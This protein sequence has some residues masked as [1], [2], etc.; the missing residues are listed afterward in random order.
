MSIATVF[1]D[2]V[3]DLLVTELGLVPQGA[4]GPG[5]PANIFKTVPPDGLSPEAVVWLNLGDTDL[6]VA[7]LRGPA[8]SGY[9]ETV[10]LEVV[11][12]VESHTANAADAQQT[13]D[14][15]AAQVT[16]AIRQAVADRHPFTDLPGVTSKA[17][18]IAGIRR[19][20]AAY[21]VK[22]GAVAVSA[23]VITHTVRSR[24]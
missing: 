21:D 22:H 3:H 20:P 8:G 19:V 5:Q 15:L 16:G 13:A 1:R 12:D 6:D 2:D 7:T 24:T 17:T 14:D 4:E 11:C 18:R 10:S 9:D 23:V